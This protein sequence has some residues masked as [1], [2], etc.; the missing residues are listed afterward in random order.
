MSDLFKMDPREIGGFVGSFMQ[1]NSFPWIHTSQPQLS[2]A[3]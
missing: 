2:V 3:Q 1:N